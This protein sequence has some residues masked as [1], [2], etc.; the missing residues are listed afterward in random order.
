MDHGGKALVYRENLATICNKV[1]PSVAREIIN[2]NNIVVM[3]RLRS[4]GNQTPYI[5]IDKIKRTLK[6]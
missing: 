3:A 5:K 4:E 2:K 6:H 1:E